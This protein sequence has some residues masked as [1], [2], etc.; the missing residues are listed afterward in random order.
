MC[1][2]HKTVRDRD[3]DKGNTQQHKE[4]VLWNGI[5]GLDTDLSR[6][7]VVSTK[8]AEHVD[9]VLLSIKV[10]PGFPRAWHCISI[11]DD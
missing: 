9:Y 10:A 1:D 4:G 5:E 11:G 7:Y 6:A 3:T 2:R 8:V